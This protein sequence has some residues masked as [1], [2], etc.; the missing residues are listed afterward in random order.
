MLVGGSCLRAGNF[1][2]N[3]AISCSSARGGLYFGSRA[4]GCGYRAC[5]ESFLKVDFGDLWLRFFAFTAMQVGVLAEF[6]CF[7][8]V[9]DLILSRLQGQGR[10]R[11]GGVSLGCF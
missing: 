1:R 5:R 2:K 9:F 3:I 7:R 4:K 10:E 6:L 11:F 8:A